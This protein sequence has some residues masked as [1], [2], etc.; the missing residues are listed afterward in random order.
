[1]MLRSYTVYGDMR[2]LCTMRCPLTSRTLLGTCCAMPGTCCYE[3]PTR[4]PDRVRSLQDKLGWAELNYAGLKPPPSSPP[5]PPPLPTSRNFQHKLSNF[6]RVC[7]ETQSG[8]S[9]FVPTSSGVYTDGCGAKG[10]KKCNA[11]GG[12]LDN[13]SSRDVE[14]LKVSAGHVALHPWS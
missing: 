4:C 10:D 11:F 3:S 13:V 6:S 2:S 8:V 14:D 7:T 5:P 12:L 1:M 9:Q